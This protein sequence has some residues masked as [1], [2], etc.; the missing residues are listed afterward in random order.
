MIRKSDKR[1]RHRW[2]GGMHLAY[3][4]CRCF[5]CGTRLLSFVPRKSLQQHWG[6]LSLRQSVRERQRRC[7]ETAWTSELADNIVRANM[8]DGVDD[9]GSLWRGRRAPQRSTRR[10]RRSDRCHDN[11]RVGGLVGGGLPGMSK[12]SFDMMA[13]G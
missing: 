3:S 11:P 7:S 4:D 5:T 8:A 12:P 2:C 13:G 10:S 9:T 6:A 1:T